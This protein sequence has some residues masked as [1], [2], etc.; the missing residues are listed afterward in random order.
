[1]DIT[2][3]MKFN[4]FNLIFRKIEYDMILMFYFFFRQLFFS[5]FT[6]KYVIRTLGKNVFDK[7]KLVR[8]YL[9]LIMFVR[10]VGHT[11]QIFSII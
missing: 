3:V 10:Y 5:F 11:T 4:A 8:V 9:L 7:I 1:M 2:Y 6:V